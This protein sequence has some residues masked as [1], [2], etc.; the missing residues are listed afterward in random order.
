MVI[1][2]NF[3]T[4]IQYNQSDMQNKLQELTEKLYQEGLVKGKEEGEALL[5]QARKEAADIVAEAEKKAA[6][7]NAKAEKDAAD[8]R[9][10]VES[11]LKMAS[12][13]CLQATKKDLENLLVG[14]IEEQ[15]VSETLK[16]AAFV[17]E[18]ILSVAQRFNS[19]EAE[20]LVLVLPESQKAELEPWVAGE[21]A[22]ALKGGVKAEFS[23][24]V[25]G[26][27]TVGPKDGGWFVS[28]TEQTFNE[29]IAE[30]LRPVT[31]KLLFGE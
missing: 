10:K 2:V 11:D 5:A 9:S 21:L 28:L 4:Q 16:D 12:A 18:I 7:I 29:L 3:K 14:K 24:K 31:R 20:D 6:A 1:F 15:K 8:L 19:E 30:Y 23:K 22:K 27:F 26:G 17:K 25:S 13:Q